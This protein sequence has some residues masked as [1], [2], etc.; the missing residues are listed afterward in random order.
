[1]SLLQISVIAFLV[2]LPLNLDVLAMEYSGTGTAWNSAAGPSITAS[3]KGRGPFHASAS[4][5]VWNMGLSC[6]DYVRVECVGDG[7]KSSPQ[8]VLASIVDRCT[9]NCNGATFILPQSGFNEIAEPNYAWVYIKY[10]A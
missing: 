9:P 6:G 10:K 4:D 5:E 8:F 2:T 3:C 1:M 7:C